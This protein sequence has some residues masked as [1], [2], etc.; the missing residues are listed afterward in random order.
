MLKRL[1]KLINGEIALGF[2]LATIFWIAVLGWVTSYISTT[3]DKEACYQSAAKTGHDTSEC[4]TFWEQTSSEPV[5]FFT[6]V[7]AFANI[8]MWIATIGLYRS[9]KNQLRLAREEFLSSHRPLLR[10]KHIWFA[11]PDGQRFF[12]RIQT[13]TPITVRLD[14]VNVGNT[15]AFVRTINFMTYLVPLD[16]YLPQRPPYNEPGVPQVAVGDFGLES[17]RTL[18]VPI[19]V[20][21]ILSSE[22]VTAIR[23]GQ[24]RL[25]FIGTIEYWWGSDRDHLRGTAFCRYLRFEWPPRPDDHGR[26]EIE[27]DPDYEYQD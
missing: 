2:Y 22:N 14:I 1:N 7:L 18:T 10:L 3:Q 26:F 20:G 24:S 27:N 13:E 4:K 6:L 17:G 9:N 12:G 23:N 15:T 8:G 25:Y 21:Q 16:Q 19:T 5:A 11:T